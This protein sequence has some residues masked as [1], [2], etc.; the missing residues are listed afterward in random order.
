MNEVAHVTVSRCCVFSLS[1][2]PVVISHSFRTNEKSRYYTSILKMLYWYWTKYA[3]IYCRMTFERFSISSYN[4]TRD[5]LSCMR[6]FVCMCVYRLN[7][8]IV[9]NF[10]GTPCVCVKCL[11]SISFV[12]YTSLL[13]AIHSIYAQPHRISDRTTFLFLISFTPR[14]ISRL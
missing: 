14:W 7:F 3:I 6:L 8:P 4:V 1:L 2:S 11:D 13:M 12:L 10:L 9:W 5:V